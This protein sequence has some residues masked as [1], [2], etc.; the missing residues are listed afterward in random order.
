MSRLSRL[1]H[2]DRIV[3]LYALFLVLLLVWQVY[4]DTRNPSD[5]GD[6]ERDQLIPEALLQHL[7]SGGTYTVDRWHGGETT[8]AA[9]EV[10]VDAESLDTE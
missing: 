5:D 10:V 4:R 9:D 7:E 2:N 6:R 1:S 3:G 8:I